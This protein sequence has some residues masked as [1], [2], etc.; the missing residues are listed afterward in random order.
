MLR[1]GLA[2]VGVDWFNLSNFKSLIP[3]IPSGSKLTYL[4]KTDFIDDGYKVKP[5]AGSSVESIVDNI[6]ETG[7]NLGLKT[8][9][10]VR[11]IMESKGYSWIDGKYGS[12]NGYDG[13]FVKGTLDNPSEIIIIESKQFKYTNN[14][15]GDL[16]EHSGVNLSPPS[17]TTPLPA[18]M[19]DDWI[20]Y[21]ADKLSKN[22]NTEALGDKILEL[23]NFDRSRISKYVT[24][25]D[26]TQGEINFLKLG[27]Y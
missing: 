20:N 24:A 19:S 12:N 17:A 25:V 7:D 14:T 11:E 6:I 1:L 22:T 16:I 5:S 4:K 27:Q 13:V 3:K 26:K 18:Q 8:E 15:A 9:A 2:N 10:A 21:V 23:M